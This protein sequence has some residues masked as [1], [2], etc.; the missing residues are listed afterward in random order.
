[1]AEHVYDYLLDAA[2]DKPDGAAL[3]FMGKP[4]S[5]GALA[6]RARKLAAGLAA[7]DIAPGSSIGLMLP[8]IPHFV[9]A[10]YG[11]W[12]N[13]NVVV[14]MNVLLTAPEVRYL[15][16]DSAIRALFVFETFLPQVEAAIADMATPPR[17]FVIG[18]AGRHVP[19]AALIDGRPQATPRRA[20]ASD[21]HLLTI[22]TSGTTGKPKGAI[23]TNRNVIAQLDMI[24]ELFETH[25]DDRALCV[26]PLFHVFALNAVLNAGIRHQSTVVLHTKFEV[27]ATLNSLQNDRIT[28]FSGVPTMYF[29]LLK[30]VGD[31]DVRFPQLHHCISGGAAMPLDV[32]RSFEA[33]F[34]VPIYEGYG[35]TETTVSV[36]CNR[37]GAKKAGSVGRPYPAVRLKIVDDEGHEVPVGSRGEVVIKSANIMQGYLNRPDATAETVVDGWLFTGDVGYIDDDGFVFIVDR[38]KDMIIKGGYNIYPREIEEVLYQMPG[39]AEAAVVGVQ[40]EA[41]GEQVR[42]VISVRPGAELDQPAIEEYLS[43]NLAKYKLPSEYIF[44]TELPKGPTGKILKRELRA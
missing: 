9:E 43:Q 11:S 29:Y 21:Q 3:E 36:C 41:K 22:Y 24:D 17:L 19:Y 2:A 31:A 37:E 42:A 23:I 33:K 1:M 14:P 15:L 26:L 12:I 25:E 7:H 13:G 20:L 4:V 44:M 27:A 40:D 6:E 8:N 18:N 34:Q 28:V 35:L 39:V 16:D 32:M 5:Y 30:Q 38:K 10:L